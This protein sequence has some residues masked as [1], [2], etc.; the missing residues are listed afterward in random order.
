[1]IKH[2]YSILDIKS[3]LFGPLVDMPNDASAIR[4][5]DGL[6][7]DNTFSTVSLYPEDFALYEICHF[8]DSTGFVDNSA[9]F[10]RHIVDGRSL[11]AYNP[12][13]LS[14]SAQPERQSEPLMA[15]H[16][17]DNTVDKEV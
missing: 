4:L 17:V 1:M 15:V 7:N 12:N 3:N 5:F 13:P 9:D 11:K 10:P 6:V 2:I 16:P 8:D 14:T